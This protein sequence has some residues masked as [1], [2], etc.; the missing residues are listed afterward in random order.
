MKEPKEMTNEELS[1]LIDAA[2]SDNMTYDELEEVGI[3]LRNHIPKPTVEVLRT[4]KK[5]GGITK[6]EQFAVA[7]MQGF[8]GTL[9]NIELATAV[10][11]VAKSKGLTM[12]RYIAHQAT[13]QADAL[14]DELNKEAKPLIEAA[15]AIDAIR[16]Q[17]DEL[18]EALADLINYYHGEEATT[19]HGWMAKYDE[20]YDLLT[21][22]KATP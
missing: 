1:I 15:N 3:R 17:R 7:A 2:S 14:I 21:R 4:A 5:D 8:I 22:I 20:A 10:E 9:S 12:E 16:T 13:I 18:V 11:R 6:R 19:T